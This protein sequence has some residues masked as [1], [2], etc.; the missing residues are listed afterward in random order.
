MFRGLANAN[1]GNLDTAINDL[2]YVVERVGGSAGFD[3]AIGL[4]EKLRERKIAGSPPS[5]SN[6]ARP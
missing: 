2:E 3:Q 5:K 1:L 6:A 4:L